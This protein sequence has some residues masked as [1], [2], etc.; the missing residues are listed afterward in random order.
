MWK[1]NVHVS[2]YGRMLFIC[3]DSSNVCYCSTQIRPSQIAGSH[4]TCF[5]TAKHFIK[6]VFFPKLVQIIILFLNKT[7]FIVWLHILCATIFVWKPFL[8]SNIYLYKACDWY[9]CTDIKVSW[10]LCLARIGFTAQL[11]LGVY[12]TIE[13]S[14]YR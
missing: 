3:I 1:R 11:L 14:Y 8:A 10:Y 7:I 9:H 5:R 2:M 12:L 6:L 13:L 4:D